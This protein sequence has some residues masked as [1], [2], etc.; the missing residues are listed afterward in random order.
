MSDE[1]VPAEAHLY[2]KLI[3]EIGISKRGDTTLSL[4]LANCTLGGAMPELVA[5]V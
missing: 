2:I 4:V 1:P 5:V 3:F